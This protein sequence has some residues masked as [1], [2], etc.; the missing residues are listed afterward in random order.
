MGLESRLKCMPESTERALIEESADQGES[1][2]SVLVDGG[3][4]AEGGMAGG[5]GD[6]EE[7]RGKGRGGQGIDVLHDVLCL[8]PLVLLHPV[9]GVA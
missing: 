8:R 3:G 9:P 4:L 1:V 7:V 6:Q 2:W 5:V